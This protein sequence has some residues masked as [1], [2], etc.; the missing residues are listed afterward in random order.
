M[1]DAKPRGPAGCA[2][3]DGKDGLQVVESVGHRWTEEA[4]A[5]FFGHLALTCNVTR[6]A[7]AAGFSATRMFQKRRD[8]PDF[9]RK[10]QAALEQGHARLEALLVQR[11]IETLE[12]FAP[13]AD[14]PIPAMTIR[15][16]TTILGHHRDRVH[17]GPRSRRSWARPRSMDEVRDSILAKLEAIA[18][19]ALLPGADPTPADDG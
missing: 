7:A 4:E 15:D 13:D 18:P 17:G 14:G 16:V 12:G 9:A 6:S 11:A 10:W 1:P 8:E 2:I 19:V 5:L 3:K